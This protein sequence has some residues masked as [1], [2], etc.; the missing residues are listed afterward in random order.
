[1]AETASES[2]LSP[3][4][5]SAVI[6]DKNLTKDKKKAP[7]SLRKF[8][9]PFRTACLAFGLLVI[10]NIIW[11]VLF[12]VSTGGMP[13]SILDIDWVRE[14]DK[15]T[16]TPDFN[17]N[18]QFISNGYIA[19]ENNLSKNIVPRITAS[20]SSKIIHLSDIMADKKPDTFETTGM[21]PRAPIEQIV[22]LSKYG[23]LPKI[24][25]LGE[26]PSDLYARPAPIS[27][28][29][30][31]I[32][33]MI[34]GLG[35]HHQA[36]QTAID[37]LPGEISFAFSPYGDGLQ[38]W[39]NR[40][41]DK[42]HEIILQTPMEPFDFP[43]NDP[44]PSTLLADGDLKLNMNRFKWI[45]SRITGYI[46]IT[47]FMG[48]KFTSKEKAITPILKELKK[49]GLY[50]VE[51]GVLHRSRVSKISKQL[52]LGFSDADVIIDDIATVENIEEAL[53]EVEKI[54]ATK[55]IAFA[56]GSNLPATVAHIK[57]WANSLAAK[58]YQLVP[59]SAKIKYELKNSMSTED[60]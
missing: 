57:Q 35:I 50:Y 17:N 54:A 3:E 56:V 22:Q 9:T 13:I 25:V 2:E 29:R 45:M 1:M 20:G 19:G 14:D 31:R 26:K 11:A 52:G 40:A 37:G 58:G 12:G 42:G 55:G 32:A 21:L 46:G 43:D 34:T 60:R 16:F 36:T 39:I 7:F 33:V 53:E 6:L 38:D 49:R 15:A 27:D 18:K 47:N 51:N 24:S 23:K 28:G 5:K 30:P 4:E 59:V 48:A 41:R 10:F 44:G 8:L